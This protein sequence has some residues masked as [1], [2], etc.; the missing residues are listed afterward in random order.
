[1]H[2]KRF[3]FWLLWMPLTAL[4][5]GLGDLFGGG[6]GFGGI[7]Y[8]PT[9]HVETAVSAAEAVKQTALQVR[10]EIQRLQSLANEFEQ[11]KA[12]PGQTIQGGLGDTLNQLNTLQQGLSGLTTLSTELNGIQNYYT[13]QLRQMAALGLSPNQ[14]IEREQALAAVQKQ[15][16]SSLALNS[17]QALSTIQ[18]SLTRLSQLQAQ[19]PASSGIH[20]SL[21]TSNQY[22]DLLASQT[23]TLVQLTAAQHQWTSSRQEAS[24]ADA[25]LAQERESNRVSQDLDQIRSLRQQIRQNEAQSGLGLMRPLP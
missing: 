6:G 4:A 7:V 18:T 16:Q 23:A 19:L 3:F 13:Q 20:Q 12:L 14:Y 1:M 17:Q 25:L 21:Q 10:A 24:D 11:L 15:S 22:L 2:R 8:D 9:N 5:F